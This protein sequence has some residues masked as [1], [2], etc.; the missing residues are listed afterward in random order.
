MPPLYKVTHGK[1]EK[2]VYSDEDKDKLVQKF[3]RE[4]PTPKLGIQ[5]YKVWVK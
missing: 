1:D 2:Y 4:N 3:L 5:R